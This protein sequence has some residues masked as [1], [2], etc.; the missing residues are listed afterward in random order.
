MQQRDC[1]SNHNVVSIRRIAFKLSNLPQTM[2][3][4]LLKNVSPLIILGFI[5]NFVTGKTT[6]EE[7]KERTR[8]MCFSL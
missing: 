7:D 1:I 3:P 4:G 6:C 8:M 5:K 2:P